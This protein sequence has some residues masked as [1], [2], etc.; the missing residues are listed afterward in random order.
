[1]QVITLSAGTMN[2]ETFIV[3]WVLLI[4]ERE[5][6]AGMF[7]LRLRVCEALDYDALCF[8]FEN[9]VVKTTQLLLDPLRADVFSSSRD[10]VV[11]E[12]FASPG[13]RD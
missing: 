9:L 3:R 2:P 10:T 7:L 13:L 1:M 4:V 6:A 11:K 8:S 12:G 5:F